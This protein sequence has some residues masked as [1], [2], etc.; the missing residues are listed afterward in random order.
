MCH[1]YRRISYSRNADMNNENN[2]GMS[3]IC[4]ITMS[5]PWKIA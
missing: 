5:V 4:V 3:T 2:N 1:T